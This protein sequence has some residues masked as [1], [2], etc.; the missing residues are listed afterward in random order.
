MKSEIL[1]KEVDG[2]EID[3]KLK[4]IE[5]E[6]RSLREEKATFEREASGEISKLEDTIQTVETAMK[7]YEDEQFFSE[8]Q[9]DVK[10][11][12]KKLAAEAEG[13]KKKIEA[14]RLSTDSKAQKVDEKIGKLGAAYL[15][16]G[17]E[18]L[19]ALFDDLCLKAQKWYT[20]ERAIFVAL[21]E[22]ID[23]FL[24]VHEG[25]VEARSRYRSVLSR[26]RTSH[27]I[28]EVAIEKMEES[29]K[30]KYSFSRNPKTIG[31]NWIVSKLKD[32]R[33]ELV[34]AER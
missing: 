31:A 14:V 9:S 7:A 1:T 10:Q 21:A 16:N 3:R 5:E 33:R 22:K 17:K 24:A 15:T 29:Q 12:L 32:I 23:H 8:D 2:Q 4:S 27:T 11:Q 34:R 25:L 19:P 13:Y 20:I 6:L 26:M 28:P 30:R 18:A